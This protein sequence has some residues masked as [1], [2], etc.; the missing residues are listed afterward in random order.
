VIR[1]KVTLMATD[2]DSS[3]ETGKEFGKDSKWWI[4]KYAYLLATLE[5]L[6]LFALAIFL[7]G[8]S[9]LTEVEESSA[10]LAEIIFAFLAGLGLLIAARGIAQRKNWARAPI[11][12]AN[13]IATPVAY[14]LIASGELIYGITLGVIA[15]P[16]LLLAWFAI[17]QIKN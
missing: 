12:L 17:P 7:I 6:I 14:Y 11:V 13:L 15:V 10:W 1:Y 5:S 9:F 8:N 4:Y 3:K 16:A 2:P